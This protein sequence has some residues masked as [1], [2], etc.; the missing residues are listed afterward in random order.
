MPGAEVPGVESSGL[1]LPGVDLSGLDLPGAELERW[2]QESSDGS[3]RAEH[4]D[5]SSGAE[6]HCTGREASFVE[7]G[8]SSCRKDP[9]QP[10]GAGVH[11]VHSERVLDYV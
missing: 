2:R 5:D 4:R 1:D 9:E 8:S 7:H 3:G 10:V 6:R 11:S